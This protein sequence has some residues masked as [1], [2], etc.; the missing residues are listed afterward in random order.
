MRE[1][2]L[3]KKMAAVIRDRGGWAIKTHGDTR[4]RRGLP[5][6]VA[7]YRSIFLGLEVKLPGKERN[8]TQLQDH[9]LQSIKEAGGVGRLVTTTD[10]VHKLLDLIDRYKG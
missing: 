4:Q 10:Q 5:D 2:D 7:C 6:V 3:S 1:S 8:L 9:T